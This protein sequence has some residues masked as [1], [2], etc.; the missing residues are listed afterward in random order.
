MG[1]NLDL[2]FCKIG[3]AFKEN[4]EYKTNLWMAILANISVVFVMFL[5]F[6][7]LS[8]LLFDF[9]NWSRYD[10]LV[11]SILLL[12]G[13][14]SELL[15][16]VRKFRFYLLSGKLNN[17][18]S[19][20]VNSIIFQ[21]VVNLKGPV[22]VVFPILFLVLCGLIFFGDYDFYFLA[23]VVFLFG[24]VLNVLFFSVLDSLAFFIKNNLFLQNLFRSVNYSVRTYTPKSL[25]NFSSLFYFFPTS[26]YAF[27]VVEILRG[28][29]KFFYFGYFWVL[30][31]FSFVLFFCLVFIWRVGLRC[32]EA[33]G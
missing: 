4:V 29:L 13:T 22:L 26:V 31:L 27:F 20:P 14:K 15:F 12:A 30:I 19:K 1:R 5:F 11:Y 7:I 18:L 16:C 17:V 28:D 23:G 21:M 9:L 25:E 3:L 6:Y 10:F 24:M 33:F 8:D 2:I 32:Y